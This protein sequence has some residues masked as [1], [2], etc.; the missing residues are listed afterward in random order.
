MITCIFVNR[1]DYSIIPLDKVHLIKKYTWIDALDPDKH[2]LKKLEE[3]TSIPIDTLKEALDTNERP[4]ATQHESYR[5][6]VYKIPTSEEKKIQTS[7]FSIFIFRNVILTL[8]KKDSTTF[9][10]LNAMGKEAKIQLLKSPANFI[11]HLID[12]ISDKYFYMLDSIE[13]KVHHLEEQIFNQSKRDIIKE[14]FKAKKALIYFHKAL[15]ANRDV[16][17]SIDKEFFFNQSFD[18]HM[19]RMIRHDVTELIDLVSTYR[20]ILTSTM[21]IYISQMSL[22]LNDIIKKMT[23]VASFILIPT[24]ISGIYGMN[25]QKMPE[26]YWTYGYGFALGLM[27]FSIVIMYI[28]FKKNDWF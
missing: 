2:E 18:T 4:R 3:K 9:Q 19:I 21:E 12:M 7:S 20:E 22:N 5:H 10:D 11:L 1:N 14:I 28:Y 25:F 26:L 15:T 6:I 8:R 17:T 24:L 23:A 27:V 13:E 16:V